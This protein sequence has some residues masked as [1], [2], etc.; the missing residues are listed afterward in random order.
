LDL[1]L[2]LTMII[3]ILEIVKTMSYEDLMDIF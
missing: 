1:F 2:A 3:K